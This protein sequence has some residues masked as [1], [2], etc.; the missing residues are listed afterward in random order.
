LCAWL[1]LIVA[2][3]GWG[4]LFAGDLWWPATFFLLA[5]RWMLTLPVLLLLPVA[6]WWR[7]R[8]VLIVLVAGVFMLVAVS[9]FSIPWR[10]LIHAA[11]PG[12]RLRVLTCNMHYDGAHGP[13]LDA[14]ITQVRPDIVALQEW[15]ED[16]PLTA[17]AG[18]GWMVARTD[19]NYVASRYPIRRWWELGHDSEAPEGAV[20]H[21]DIDTDAG[22]VHFFSLHLLSP[23]H[24]VYEALRDLEGFGRAEE[25]TEL[26]WRQSEFVA[27]DAADLSDPIVLVGDFNTAPESA[28]WRRV[29]GRYRDAFDVAGWGWGHTFHGGKTSV[30]IDHVLAGPGWYVERCWVGPDVGSPH[31]P[32]IADLIWTADTR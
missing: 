6:A 8:S 22:L 2:V 10:S 11:P 30:R 9:G 19:H 20:L 32:V 15:V 25:E 24:G 3:A 13:R 7:R 31:R 17:V 1:Y 26:R 5:P 12:P 27:S 28:L 23:R 16:A 29:W 4:L 14:L 21:C 18:A